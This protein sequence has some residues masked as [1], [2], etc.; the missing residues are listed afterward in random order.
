MRGAEPDD[1]LLTTKQ[2]ADRLGVSEDCVWRWRYLRR[3]P[4]YIRRVGRIF[5]LAADVRRWEL[6]NRVE[7]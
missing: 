5:Y 3:G 4:P 7:G 1:T 2:V 6:S